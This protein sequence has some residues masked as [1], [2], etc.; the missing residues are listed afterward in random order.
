LISLNALSRSRRIVCFVREQRV[1]LITRANAMAGHQQ[2]EAASATTM[3]G[4]RDTAS[5]RSGQAP[6]QEARQDSRIKD[7]LEDDD[8]REALRLLH[9]VKP[10]SGRPA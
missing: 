2:D 5:V 1:P 3:K 10:A 6:E 4:D 8:V 7:M 9:A